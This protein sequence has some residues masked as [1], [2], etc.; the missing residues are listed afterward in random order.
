MQ[1][2]THG[3]SIGIERIANRFLLTLKASGKLTH[4][5]FEMISPMIDAALGVVIEPRVKALI[6]A[7][8]LEG[9]EIRTAW[10]D[11]KL[12]LKHGNEFEKVAIVGNKDS[13]QLGVNLASWIISGELKN[14]E[15][16][17]EAIKWLDE[18]D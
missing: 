7:T 18:V 15:E 16:L 2:A 12:A 14:F 6:D 13:E 4:E 8:E 1:V 3:L 9:W 17:S 5:D 11:F 10:D